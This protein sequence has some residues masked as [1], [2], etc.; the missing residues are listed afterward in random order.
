[1]KQ[2]EQ[3]KKRIKAR[4]PR[5]SRLRRK[6]LVASIFA[7]LL[8]AALLVNLYYVSIVKGPEYAKMAQRQWQSSLSL[9]AERGKILDPGH[10]RGRGSGAYRQHPFHP[11]QREL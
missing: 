11:A 7:V 1:M 8:L 4:R 10:H 6:L 2:R 5:I 3:R 9:K